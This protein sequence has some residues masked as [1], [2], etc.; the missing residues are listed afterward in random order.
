MD[1]RCHSESMLSMDVRSDLEL[2]GVDVRGDSESTLGINNRS[3]SESILS[4]SYRSNYGKHKQNQNAKPNQSKFT[5]KF[6][7]KKF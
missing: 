5:P 3:E 4:S 2:L 7:K 1:V 6:L